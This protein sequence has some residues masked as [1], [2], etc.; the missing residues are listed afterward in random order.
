MSHNLVR[1]FEPTEFYVL[2][3]QGQPHA[4]CRLPDCEQRRIIIIT[5]LLEQH[6][7]STLDYARL[8]KKS[9][10]RAEE[11]LDGRRLCRCNWFNFQ[12]KN[13]LGDFDMF[14]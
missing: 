12:G 7:Y 2:F 11:N 3:L 14:S 10:I 9:Y 8:G 1:S 4:K 13:L 5:S 6:C